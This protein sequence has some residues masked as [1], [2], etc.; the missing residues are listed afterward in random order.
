M[1]LLAFGVRANVE[2]A[3]HIPSSGAVK[4]EPQLND[5]FAQG[6]VEWIQVETVVVGINH[7][8][9]SLLDGDV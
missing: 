9:A 1:R 3:V 6:I 4:S 5:S 2:P 7:G 8:V